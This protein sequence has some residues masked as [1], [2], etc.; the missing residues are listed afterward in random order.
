MGIVDT[1]HSLATLAFVVGSALVAVRLLA[2]SARTRRAPEFLLGSGILLTAVLGYGL[3]IACWILRGT[4]STTSAAG[5]TPLM[6]ALFA[7]G[8]ISHD[9]GV[10]LFL[11]FVMHVFRRGDVRAWAFAGLLM[12]LLWGGLALSVAHGHFRSDPVGTLGWFSEY[13]VIWTYSLWNVVESY[14]YWAMMRRRSRVG[15]V[16]P[17][18]T[19]RFFLWGT[20]SVFTA[21]A[22][23]TASIPYLYMADPARIDAITP[24]VRIVTALVGL[25]SVSCSLLAFVPPAW[26]RRLVL[27][28]A[29]QATE[30]A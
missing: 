11:I 17:M 20:S 25:A 19:N 4:A 21:L 18:V 23:W 9:L 14:R 13:S 8:K 15:I 3:L 29:R 1:F 5:A 6:V 22:T 7:A 28:G 26:Y 10:S 16:E 2:L 24:A 12:F 30:S 27:T